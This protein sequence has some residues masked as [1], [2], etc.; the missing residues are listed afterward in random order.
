MR[1][2]AIGIEA[3]PASARGRRH[4]AKRGVGF[5]LVELLVVVAI[6]GIVLALAAVNLVP[7]DVEVARR[8]TGMVAVTIEKARDA[9]WFGGRPTALSFDAGRLRQWRLTG[10][11]AWAPDP[12]VDRDLGE[13][14]VAALYVD[15]EALTAHPRLLFLPDGLGVPFRLTLEVR[16]QARSIEGEA[17]GAESVQ[18]R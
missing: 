8:E 15:G 4:S 14:R 9:A 16:G 17:A 11:R 18:E 2:S 10:E 12:A 1:I 6:V 5:T 3:G 7:S 13:V